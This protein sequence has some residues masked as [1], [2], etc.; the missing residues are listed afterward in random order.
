MRCP[1]H[2][3]SLSDSR[4]GRRLNATL[5]PLPSPQRVSPVTRIT[6]PACRSH[7]P[8]GSDRCSRR[9]LPHPCGLPRYA[10][11][12]ASASSLS[13]PAQD[14]LTL[15]PAGSLSRPRRPLSRG[16]RSAGYP[17]N[18]LVSYQTY[19]QLSGWIPPPLVTRALRGTQRNPG[20]LHTRMN[21]GL[22]YRSI[23]ACMGMWLSRGMI[24][25]GMLCSWL[26]VWSAMHS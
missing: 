22:R 18:L 21:P 8:G 4:R 11:G 16:F 24:D 26:L 6:L 5:R 20:S 3:T 25:Q 9:L 23:R 13:R 7:Y 15:R 12:S 17:T 1:A 19:R 10:G 2:T 14:S